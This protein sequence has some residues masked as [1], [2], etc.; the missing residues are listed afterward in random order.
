MT[1]INEADK[2]YLGA[3]AVD[4][5]YS[6][7]NLVWPVFK[8]TDLP[9]L[10]IWLDA[11]QLAGA[12]GS[13]VS[14]WPNLAGGAPGTMMTNPGNYILPIVSTNTLNGLKIVRFYNSQARMRMTGIGVTL[15]Y[16]VA[17]VARM[18]PGGIVGRIVTTTYP[19][20]NF[21]LGFWNGFEDVAYS[22]SGAFFVP[23]NRPA[24]SNNWKL[25]SSDAAT[26][27]WTPRMFS[28][29][30][31]LN[32][33]STTSGNPTQD[34][35]GNNFNISGYDASTTAETCDCEIAEVVL[36]DNKLADADRQKVEDY[37]RAKWGL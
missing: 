17:Y 7:A 34:G 24:A 32:T 33:S 23:D 30:V 8:P 18:V 11:S 13:D 25:Y 20:N 4:R 22:T 12:Q 21:L 36:Y 37:L 26:P 3:H 19:D 5:I 10:R 2:L 16:T 35:W 6:G 27:V 28:N 14:P 29:G 1:V 31:L 15:D 9:G